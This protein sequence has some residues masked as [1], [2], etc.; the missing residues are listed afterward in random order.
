MEPRRFRYDWL[1]GLTA[2][3]QAYAEA[4]AKARELRQYVING[5]PYERVRFGDEPWAG[6]LEDFCADCRVTRG[7]FHLPGCDIE[8]CPRCSGQVVACRCFYDEHDEA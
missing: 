5:Q 4:L 2:P 6:E 8:Q 3:G 1:G 7:D